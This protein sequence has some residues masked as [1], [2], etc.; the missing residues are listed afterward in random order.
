MKR[1]PSICLLGLLLLTIFIS[2]CLSQDSLKKTP[3]QNSDTSDDSKLK[4]AMVTD[5]NGVSDESFNQSAWDGFKKLKGEGYRT[6]LM[7]SKSQSDYLANFNELA[8][9]GAQLIFGI[10]FDL[11]GA[12]IE[13]AN[14]N[15]DKRFVLVD[16]LITEKI[17]K[18]VLAISFK[19]EE[20]SFLAGF[21]SASKIIE[22]GDKG[23]IALMIGMDVPS[24][25][26]YVYGFQAGV[27]AASLAFGSP[28]IEVRV[29]YLDT[30]TN[31]SVAKTKASQEY[32]GGAKVIVSVAGGANSGALEAAKEKDKSIILTDMDNSDKAPKNIITTILK[33]VGKAVEYTVRSFSDEEFGK[34][35]D[36]GIAEGCVGVPEKN[37][38]VSSK[39]M[40]K[41]KEFEKKI[42]SKQ[43]KIP[44]NKEGFEEFKKNYK[45]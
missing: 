27:H 39:T 38:N 34:N 23:H 44:S 22:E 43:I 16:K 32:E 18:N 37:P 40:S 26:P 24:M 33:D 42:I 5:F 7:E 9:R 8:Q 25:H 17:P 1:I 19:S 45:P 31:P 35:K 12:I 41:V 6:Y 30:F 11:E 28:E 15:P 4:I 36:L 20:P 13:S 29:I 14:N 2:G 3:S 10:G 21:M